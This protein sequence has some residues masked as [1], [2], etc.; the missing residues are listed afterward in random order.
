MRTFWSLC[1]AVV[2]SLAL[3]A[4]TSAGII[5]TGVAEPPPPTPDSMTEERTEQTNGTI[6]TD[7]AESEPEAVTEIALSLLQNVLSLF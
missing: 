6:H 1:A 2:L 3:A 5:S 7:V 4:P